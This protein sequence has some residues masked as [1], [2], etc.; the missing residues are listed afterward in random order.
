[1]LNINLQSRFST[2]VIGILIF[3]IP[4]FT[5]LSPENL[6]QLSGSDLLEVFLSLIIV[7]VLIFISSSS[8]EFLIKKIFNKK[9]ILFPFLC[10]AFYVHFL[11][12]PYSNFF[13]EILIMWAGDIVTS[14]HV[15]FMTLS[16]QEVAF[17]LFELFCFGLIILGSKFHFFS[18]RVILIFSI[19]M[20]MNA[21]IPLFGYLAHKNDTNAAITYE[22]D[23]SYFIQDK[24]PIKRNV[25]FIILDGMLA[26]EPADKLNITSKKEVISRLSKS[27][28]RYVDQSMSSYSGTYLTLAALM[29]LD[30]P[31]QPEAPNYYNTANFFPR[32]M[33]LDKNEL[34][35]VSFLNV[36][37]SSFFWSGNTWAGCNP[38]SQWT[39]INSPS[40]LVTKNS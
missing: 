36:A 10:L 33:T 21:L 19:A 27:E 11:Y 37:N 1:M 13:Q 28:L 4:F 14:P 3:F 5:F 26:L 17:I 31:H 34:P 22:I 39:C 16:H 29:I 7:L 15:T 2:I 12:L 30:Y 8:F 25:Y 6:N 32:M 24:V 20:M 9:I 38:S 23:N 18:L 35:L 40:E